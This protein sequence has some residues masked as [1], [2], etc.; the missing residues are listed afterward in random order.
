MGVPV[1]HAEGGDFGGI[2]LLQCR[3]CGAHFETDSSM[4]NDCPECGFQSWERRDQ[5]DD[6]DH[7]PWRESDLYQ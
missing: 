7:V 4:T 1:G 2:H 5:T 6:P 3:R